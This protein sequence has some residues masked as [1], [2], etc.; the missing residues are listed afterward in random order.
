MRWR[1]WAGPDLGGWTGGDIWESSQALARLLAA[2]PSLIAGKRVVELGCGCGL[3]GLTA[4]GLGVAAEVALTDQVLFMAQ[5]NLER[6]FSAEERAAGGVRVAQLS[7]GSAD[8]IWG[9]LDSSDAAGF[10]VLMGAD[11]IYHA[12]S[13]GALAE[14]L[15]A[16]SH[17]GSVVLWATQV[18]TPAPPPLPTP[19]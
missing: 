14:T 17:D 18:R 11:I 5:R 10:D 4:A 3:L 6:N 15:S 2:R 16:L 7:W 12:E 8:D 1:R 9:L 19:H 13:H